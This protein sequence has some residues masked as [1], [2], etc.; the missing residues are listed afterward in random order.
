MNWLDQQY[1][2][3]RHA[4]DLRAAE[5]RAETEARLGQAKTK[6]TKP[7]VKSVRRT[8]GS[9]LIEFGERL[10]DQPLDSMGGI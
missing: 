1:Q 8:V 10:Q 7:K 6:R 3:E 4:D 9:K 2:N 5:Q